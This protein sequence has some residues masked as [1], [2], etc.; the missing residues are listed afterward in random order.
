LLLDANIND[1][2]EDGSCEDIKRK[3]LQWFWNDI[4]Y[5]GIEPGGSDFLS[6]MLTE[7]VCMQLVTEPDNFVRWFSKIFP[8][9]GEDVPNGLMY[10]AVIGRPDDPHF[11]HLCGL[12][13]SRAWCWRR[14]ARGLPLDYRGRDRIVES[15]Q[16][17]L[18]AGLPYIDGHYMRQH[19]LATF[20]AL[21]LGA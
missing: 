12:N 1:W 15:A 3:V 16:R 21:A 2:V 17:H 13:L 18:I 20:A 19:W 9:L 7:A 14:I 4:D 10:P 6:P 5:S 11:G 8:R